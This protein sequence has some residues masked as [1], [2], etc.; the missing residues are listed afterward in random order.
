MKRSLA[1]I[2]AAW[3]GDPAAD[4][5]QAAHFC[6]VVYD[7][8]YSP[9]CPMLY[10]PLFLNDAVPEEHKNGIDMG[11]DL[12]RRSRVLVVCGHT[13]TES[14]KN[15]IA[16]AQ[17]LGITATT[18]EGILTVKAGDEKFL[19]PH[20]VH[21][22]AFQKSLHLLRGSGEFQGFTDQLALVVFSQVGDVGFKQGRHISVGPGP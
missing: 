19:I 4:M 6:R 22:D 14:M 18:L 10:L 1:Y 3:R 5:E 11:R 13:V 21:A 20:P 15:D 17:R 2:T 9:I 7:A 8:G 16:V 12:L